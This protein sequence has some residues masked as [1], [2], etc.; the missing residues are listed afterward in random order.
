[1]NRFWYR[2]LT[3]LSFVAYR[4][5]G[6]FLVALLIVDI[7]EV[8][9]LSCTVEALCAD[10]AHNLLKVLIAMRKTALLMRTKSYLNTQLREMLSE[11]RLY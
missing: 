2:W 9:G 4:C 7:G 11:P 3:W 1:M 10:R 6:M 8:F 5:N